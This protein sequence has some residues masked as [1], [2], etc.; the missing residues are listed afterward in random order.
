[1]QS[2]QP[3]EDHLG[4]LHGNR[5]RHRAGEVLPQV[6]EEQLHGPAVGV[7]M[8]RCVSGRTQVDVG[9]SKLRR[10]VLIKVGFHNITLDFLQTQHDFHNITLDF[11]MNFKHIRTG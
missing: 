2:R 3:G 6:C 4:L 10:Q 9:S 8:A 1:M 7:Q 5:A 11:L